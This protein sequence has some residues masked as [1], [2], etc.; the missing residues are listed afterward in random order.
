MEGATVIG[1]VVQRAQTALAAGCDMV[2]VC[3]DPEAADILLAELKWDIAAVSII[4]LARM[5]GSP[6]PASIAELRENASFVKAVEQI[7]SI[8]IQSGELPLA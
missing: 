5:R 7:S 2:L 1:D 3:N 8:G 6:H 4:R